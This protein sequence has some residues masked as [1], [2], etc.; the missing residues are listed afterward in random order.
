MK[1]QLVQ[2]KNS[3]P[4]TNTKIELHVTTPVDYV[5][6]DVDSSGYFHLDDK[7]KGTNI[8]VYRIDGIKSTNLS[9]W[10][11]AE[12][13]GVIAIEIAPSEKNDS[14]SF[15]SG[16]KFISDKDQ[17]E[18]ENHSGYAPRRFK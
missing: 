5:W 3:Q 13:N 12:D 14:F 1:I 6:V 2:R 16:Q 17:L 9:Y 11:R 4:Y 10:T 15:M 18:Y 8:S 7:Y